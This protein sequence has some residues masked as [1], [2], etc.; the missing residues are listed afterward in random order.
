MGFEDIRRRR[1]SNGT[2]GGDQDFNDA[3]F[4]VSTDPSSAL[5]KSGIAI[6][7]TTNNDNDGDGIV[8]GDELDADTDGDG[9]ANVNDPDDDGD[10]IVNSY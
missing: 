9:I 10:G 3:V 6:A 5:A 7:N 4:S 2:V 1:F 8:N